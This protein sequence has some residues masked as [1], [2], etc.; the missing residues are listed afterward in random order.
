MN[1][2]KENFGFREKKNVLENIQF[3]SSVEV[4]RGHIY[5][6]SIPLASITTFTEGMENNI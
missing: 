6:L 5:V 1:P 3:N 4:N 2:Q